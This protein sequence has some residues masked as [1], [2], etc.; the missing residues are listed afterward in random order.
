M[1]RAAGDVGSI[2]SMP[3]FEIIPA[4]RSHCAEIACLMRDDHREAIIALD[5]DPYREI[6]E[7]FNETPAPLAWLIDGQISVLGGIA[8][9]PSLVP[10][11]NPWAIVAGHA[12]RFRHALVRELRRQLD[13]AQQTY[14]MLVTPLC[15]SDKKS[16]RLAEALGFAVEHAFLQDGLLHV[17]RA[18]DYQPKCWKRQRR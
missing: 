6:T 7:A 14:P 3:H 13:A 10:I 16:V 15:R 8:G 5:L 18:P 1:D 17:V 11:G 2:P 4:K 12:V 9:P